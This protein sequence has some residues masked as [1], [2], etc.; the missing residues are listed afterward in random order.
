ML[1][2]NEVHDGTYGGEKD[3]KSQ[4]VGNTWL[5]DTFKHKGLVVCGRRA[6]ARET[7]VVPLGGAATTGDNSTVKKMGGIH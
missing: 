5:E 4:D 6:V 7:E 1:K 3:Q 2:P